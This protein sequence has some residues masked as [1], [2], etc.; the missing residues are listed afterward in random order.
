MFDWLNLLSNALWII[1]CAFTLA[2]LSYA[3]WKSST[4]Q[5]KLLTVLRGYRYQIAL[6][7]S[8]V[9]FCLGMAATSE[10]VWETLIWLLLGFMF[11]TQLVRTILKNGKKN[12]DPS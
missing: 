2:T 1:A 11:A 12:T 7:L 4:Q 6:N 3:S 8:G 10:E 9:L 5:A